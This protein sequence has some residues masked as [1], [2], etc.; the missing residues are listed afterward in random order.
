MIKEDAWGNKALFKCNE[1][2]VSLIAFKNIKFMEKI[3]I[4]SK[5]T[6][7]EKILTYLLQQAQIL[8]GKYFTC[9]MGR[10]EMADYLC[11]NRSALF[12]QLTTMKE[13]GILD[14]DK[15]TFR[16]LHKD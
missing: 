2:M 6:L 4:I 11:S 15:N 12:R 10:T 7:R 5:K 8:G 13:E 9:P 1:R 16:L 3:E 14:C